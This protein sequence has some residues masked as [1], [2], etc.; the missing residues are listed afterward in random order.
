VYREVYSHSMGPKV[1]GMSEGVRLEQF[2]EAD[3][4]N[5]T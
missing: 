3:G 2:I 1:L 4:L 5:E